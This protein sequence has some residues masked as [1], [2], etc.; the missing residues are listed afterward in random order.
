MRGKDLN[1]EATSCV[2]QWKKSGIVRHLGKITTMK[3]SQ[4]MPYVAAIIK[5]NVVATMVECLICTLAIIDALVLSTYINRWH[6]RGHLS[7]SILS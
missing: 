7:L 5:H 3:Q 6:N 4:T 1:S 2:V